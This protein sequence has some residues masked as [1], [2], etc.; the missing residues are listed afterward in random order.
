MRVVST[1]LAVLAV[2]GVVSGCGASAPRGIPTIPQD[3]SLDVAYTTLHDAGFRVAIR[4]P[5]GRGAGPSSFGDV[6]VKRV[7]PEAGSPAA[8]A[9]RAR[10]AVTLIP[11]FDMY[12]VSYAGLS[13]AVP[14]RIPSLLGKSPTAA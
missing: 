6:V 1:V 14:V 10:D 3:S 4:F 2:S 13:P 8:A 11:W 9:L 7:L 5:H 12:G